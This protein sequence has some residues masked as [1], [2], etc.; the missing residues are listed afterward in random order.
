MTPVP[1][2]IVRLRNCKDWEAQ[3]VVKIVFDDTKLKTGGLYA[4]LSKE[5]LYKVLDIIEA[6]YAK[7]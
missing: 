6:E 4:T 1:E 5:T 7:R 3:P 2:V